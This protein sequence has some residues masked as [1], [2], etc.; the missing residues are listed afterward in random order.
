MGSKCS[1]SCGV[2]PPLSLPRRRL[3]PV[4]APAGIDNAMR[5][6]FNGHGLM[7]NIGYG[8]NAKTRHVLP[9]G[10][11]KMVVKNVADLELLMMHNRWVQPS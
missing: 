6:K 9:S 5:R 3:L 8:T 7:P 1:C 4:L 11:M 10:F 2:F